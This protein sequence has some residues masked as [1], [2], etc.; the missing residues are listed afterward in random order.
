[1][2]LTREGFRHYD[3]DRMLFVSGMWDQLRCHGR[4]GWI[5]WKASITTLPVRTFAVCARAVLERGQRPSVE[6]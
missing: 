2:A 6:R 5:D 1:M 3:Y 4:P